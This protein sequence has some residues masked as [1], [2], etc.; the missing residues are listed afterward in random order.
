M[1]DGPSPVEP[2]LSGAILIDRVS[3]T[4]GVVGIAGKQTV[5]V[6]KHSST[7]DPD[8]SGVILKDWINLSISQ[9][10]RFCVS[11]DGLP[12]HTVQ[13]VKNTSHP[14]I[15]F[16]VGI[17]YRWGK[18]KSLRQSWCHQV[19]LHRIKFGKPETAV[20]TDGQDLQ[21]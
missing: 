8:R 10:L 12:A 9:P 18:F 16:P 20:V 2:Y 6:A 21:R 15:A 17:V 19:A 3:T 14:D 1:F 7:A 11:R 13:S 4:G 5:L